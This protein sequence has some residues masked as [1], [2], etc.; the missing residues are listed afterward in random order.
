MCLKKSGDST[1][2]FASPK[3][4]EAEVFLTKPTCQDDLKGILRWKMAWD[5]LVSV[6]GDFHFQ[7]RF[8]ICGGQ[9]GALRKKRPAGRALLAKEGPSAKRCLS[10][11]LFRA[12]ALAE[13]GGSQPAVRAFFRQTGDQGI[14]PESLPG[15]TIAADAL[16]GR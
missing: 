3:G 12:D 6:R 10:K 4:A 7:R 15:F 16:G 5:N 9:R 8:Y 11:S 2:N 14:Y 1:A 13:A